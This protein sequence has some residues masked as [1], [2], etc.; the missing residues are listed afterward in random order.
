MFAF[1]HE[2]VCFGL[3]FSLALLLP[4]LADQGRLEHTSLA[5]IPEV[6]RREISMSDLHNHTVGA[7]IARFVF[8]SLGLPCF[9]RQ[10][11]WE[12]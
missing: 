7:L 3:A 8:V 11:E 5:P 4:K 9:V 12:F 1:A 10:A 6:Q 2:L